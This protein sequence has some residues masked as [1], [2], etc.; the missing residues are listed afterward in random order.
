VQSAHDG[1]TAVDSPD[2]QAKDIDKALEPWR[3]GDCVVGPCWF[4]YRLDPR[5]PLRGQSI[6][7]YDPETGNTEEPARGFSVLTQSCDLARC[8]ED[9]SFVEVAP[10][11]E[12]SE[13]DWHSAA[14]GRLPRYAVVPGL[15]DQRLVADLDRVMT[16]EKAVVARWSRIPGCQSDDERRAFGLALARKRSRTAFPDAFVELIRPLQK[17][18]VEKHDKQ[19]E[20]GRALRALREIRV[21]AAPDW[22]AVPAELTFFFLRDSEVVDFEGTSWDTYLERWLDLVPVTERF[23]SPDGLVVTLD[24]LTARDY[25][26]SDLLDLGYLSERSA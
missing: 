7:D 21:R 17:R 14:R 11:V 15:K 25:V 2:L 5:C 18:L 16:M 13:Q 1:A 4:L 22:D 12:L 26:E 20:E 24:D 9:R 23:T 10:L 3:Q 19:T 6:E 8:C